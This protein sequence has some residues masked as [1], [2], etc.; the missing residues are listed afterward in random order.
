MVSTGLQLRLDHRGNILIPEADHTLVFPQY[1]VGRL[2][3]DDRII[4]RLLALVRAFLSPLA[5]ELSGALL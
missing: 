5:E 1:L 2:L 4:D 3:E